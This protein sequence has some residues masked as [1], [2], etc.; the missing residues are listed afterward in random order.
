MKE[1]HNSEY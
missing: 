1:F